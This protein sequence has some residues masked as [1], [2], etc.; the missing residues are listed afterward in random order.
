METRYTRLCNYNIYRI[1]AEVKK[2]IIAEGGEI[3]TDRTPHEINVERYTMETDA[4]KRANIDALPSLVVPSIS[5]T[6]LYSPTIYYVKDGFYYY[7]S[8][9]DNP[10]FPITYSKIAIDSNGNYNG[11][12]YIY[13]SDD[14]N[15]RAW[16]KSN[17][18]VFSIGYDA[19]WKII[20]DETIKE[21][22]QDH[23]NAIKTYVEN[24]RESQRVSERKRVN[25]YYNNGYHYETIYDNKPHSIHDRY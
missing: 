23:Y 2:L 8:Y 16:K 14:I 4:Q 1:I 21:L 11:S 24:G 17:E 18:I 20:D 12:R 7:I 6:S 25:N 9:D 3:L 22:A 13:S 5:A 15:D 19:I 10:F